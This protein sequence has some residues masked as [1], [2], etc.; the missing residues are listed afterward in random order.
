MGVIK[1]TFLTYPG[2]R[3]T[4]P[5]SNIVFGSTCVVLLALANVPLIHFTATPNPLPL[6]FAA[7]ALLLL[8][9]SPV[10]FTPIRHGWVVGSVVL[11]QTLITFWW[12][13]Y[14][15]PSGLIMQARGKD[16]LNLRFLPQAT[17]YWKPPH[18]AS[19][20]QRSS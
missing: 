2:A 16:P 9:W 13:F 18:P 14:I 11:C 4:Q 3:H 8:L 15:M 5:E 7:L 19:S 17:S 6:M 20:M 10:S 1:S 12:L